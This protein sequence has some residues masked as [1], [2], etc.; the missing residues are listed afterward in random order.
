MRRVLQFNVEDRYGYTIPSPEKVV[1]LAER[2]GADALVVFARDP[3]GRAFYRGSSVHP[4]HPNMKG[5]FVREIIELAHRKGIK[6]VLMVAHTANQYHFLKHREWAQVNRKGEVVVL[7]HIP[8]EENGAP[9]WP[10][11]CINSPYFEVMKKEVEEAKELGAD[12]IFLDSFRYQPDPERACVCKY[13]REL[14][15]EEFP[16]PKWHDSRWRKEWEWRFQITRE[17]LRELKAVAGDTPLMYNSHPGGWAGR[18]NRVVEDN[19]DILDYVFAESSEADHQP[20]GFIYEMVKLTKAMGAKR[21]FASRN[22]FHM[23]RTTQQTTDVAIRQ[24]MRE[25]IISGGTAWVLLFS[26]L[27]EYFDPSPVEQVFKEMERY[28]ELLDYPELEYTGV[29]FS[30]KTRDYYGRERPHLYTDEVRGFFYASL[31]IHLPTKYV[32]DVE[33]VR[34]LVL[35]DLACMGER[36]MEKVRTFV[37]EGGRVVATF[38]TSSWNGECVKGYELRLGDLFGVKTRGLLRTPWSYVDA[39]GLGVDVRVPWGDMSYEFV[40]SRTERRLGWHVMT[41][42]EGEVLGKVYLASQWS[43]PEYTL[44]RSPPPVGSGTDI[45]FAVRNRYGRGESVYISGLLGS[46]YWRTGLHHYLTMIRNALGEGLPVKVRA[47][48]SVIVEWRKEGNEIVLFILNTTYNQRIL[49]RGT[50]TIKQ[51]LKPFSSDTAVH[52][53]RE[54]IPVTVS[55]EL[56]GKYRMRL[57]MGKEERTVEGRADILVDEFEAVVLKRI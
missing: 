19:A 52:P 17:R 27:L 54:V 12:I 6:V 33:S 15:G 7:E 48:S 10:V 39:P 4:P 16:P 53:P 46:M 20:P 36:E 42:A 37:E 8:K 47:P 5:D 34:V 9:E 11:L 45:P 26:N 23:Y 14:F 30:T 43:G 2:I 55:L 40:E 21:V 3:W 50:G 35:P 51:A 24:G 25:S 38:L 22:V 49:A 18:T 56:D 32:N 28:E 13:C 1:E 29:R 44:G 31:H 57:V 41:E